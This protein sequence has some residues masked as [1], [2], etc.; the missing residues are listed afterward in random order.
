M[1]VETITI[2]FALLVAIVGIPIMVTR[3]DSDDR[4]KV[5]I[6]LE[7]VE[8]AVALLGSLIIVITETI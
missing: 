1:D 5:Y 8:I 4:F 7:I 3:D 6:T 2:L